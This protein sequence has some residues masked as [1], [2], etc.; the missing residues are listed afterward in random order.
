MD[1]S[2][3]FTAI[4]ISHDKGHAFFASTP[5]SSSEQPILVKVQKRPRLDPFIAQFTQGDAAS[6][7][8][9]GALVLKQ[10]HSNAQYNNYVGSLPQFSAKAL[11]Y[12]LLPEAVSRAILAP[13]DFSACSLAS[14]DAY[15]VE[16]INPATSKNI[17]RCTPSPGVIM[18]TET[19]ALYSGVVEPYVASVSDDRTLQWVYN[20]V[21]V[22]KE[23]E[24]LLLNTDEFILNVDT[25]WKKHCDCH[26]PQG[27]WR[28]H[29]DTDVDELYCLAIVKERGIRTLRDLRGKHI[30]LLEGI[31]KEAPKAIE[32]VYGVKRDQLRLFVHY[33]PQ[34][35][36]LHIHVT[37]LW[38][39]IGCQVERAHLVSDIVQN[40]KLDGDYYEK[41]TITYK[42]PLNDKLCKLIVAKREEESEAREE[43]SEASGEGD[44]GV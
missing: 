31:L 28:G 6:G 1:A 2:R 16:V 8:A 3:S 18:V 36:H 41:R 19:P 38:N 33:I 21:D 43:E 17:Q 10:T 29:A 15:D 20:C 7:Q 35:M 12:S 26:V 30:G 9:L 11:A 4:N 37:R 42:L 22:K 34:F 24:R 39:D 14:S 32:K 27:E 25:K 23:E 44:Q 40:L 5:R 13:A